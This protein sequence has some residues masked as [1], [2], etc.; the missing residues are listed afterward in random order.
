MTDRRRL[1]FNGH[2]ALDSLRD[3]ID[4]KRFTQG[5]AASIHSPVAALIPEPGGGGLSKQLIYGEPVVVIERGAQHSF[6]Q[7][8]TDQY[9]GYV[10]TSAL[11]P[12]LTP[13]HRITAHASHAYSRA[14]FKSPV[15]AGLS[16]GSRVQALGQTE[17]FIETSLGYIPRQ[18]LTPISDLAPDPVTYAEQFLGTPYLWGANSAWGIDCSGLLQTAMLACGRDCPRDSDM[19]FAELGTFLINCAYPKRGDLVFWKGHVGIMRDEATLLHANA[20]HMAVA[21]E[22]LDQAIE[23]IGAQE[24][25]AVTGFKRL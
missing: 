10:A 20:Y 7:S 12:V 16:F 18:H 5:S 4:A 25:G 1:G 6:V 3:Q 24:F 21:S 19:Q 17:R 22:P 15:Q 11:G 13:S 23:R 8:Q 9:A 2:V 14:D